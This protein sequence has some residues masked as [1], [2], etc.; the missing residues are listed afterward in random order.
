MVGETKPNNAKSPWRDEYKVKHNGK[1]VIK[2]SRSFAKHVNYKD[3]SE[4]A[5]SGRYNYN[6]IEEIGLLE[7]SP[8]A[9]VSNE[10]TVSRG[11]KKVAS[12]VG[13]GTSGVIE[14]VEGAKQI[15]LYPFTYDCVPYKDYL[16]HNGQQ[17]Y[18]CLLYTS[19]EHTRRHHVS[20]MPSSA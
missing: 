17:G 3:D 20:R 7:D 1:E 19:P 8:T 6:I 2:G 10:F 4:A 12:L 15:F 18:T 9:W 13:L 5:A 11:V 16:E 14:K